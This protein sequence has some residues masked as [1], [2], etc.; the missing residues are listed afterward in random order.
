MTEA[1]DAAGLIKRFGKVT[2]LDGLDLR[3]RTGEVHG[4]LGP[5]GAGKT[6]AIR[7]LLGLTR[8]DGGRARLLGGDPW[9]DATTLHRRLAYVPGDV[10]FW[11]NLTGG[12]VIDLLGR[13][14]GGLDRRRRDDL[15]ERFQ[16]D[17]RK[18][19][20]TYSKG[21]RQK[22]ALVA[23]LA[24]DVELLLL[25]EPTSGLDPLMEEVFREVI[26]QEKLRGD[27]TVLLSSHILAEVEALCDRVTII[28]AGRAV[29]TG[30]LADLRHLTRTTIRA[31]L[32]GPVNGLAGIAG[33]HDLS[34][35]DGRVAFDVDAEALEPALRSLVAAGVR[36]LV[37]QPP[38]LEELF[39]RHY[40]HDEAGK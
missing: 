28:R 40:A 36:S 24:S 16:L 21:N 12:E 37:S 13:L 6:T 11:P 17:P 10:T 29:E 2:A 1:I 5:N 38:S 31:E 34:T 3:V 19:S 20:R 4:F 8:L 23:A 39:L 7:I 32:T 18:K 26:L 9:A 35:A 30:T 33:V 15:V 27:R 14:R 22:V 25:D